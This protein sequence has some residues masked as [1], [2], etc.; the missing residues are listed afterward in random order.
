MGSGLQVLNDRTAQTNNSPVKMHSQMDLSAGPS[1]SKFCIYEVPVPTPYMPYCPNRSQT[2]Q[3]TVYKIQSETKSERIETDFFTPSQPEKHET[4]VVKSNRSKL[5]TNNI[6]GL[7]SKH[8][9][10]PKESHTKVDRDYKQQ[11]TQ[12]RGKHGNAPA[13]YGFLERRSPY[14]RQF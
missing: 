5:P 8:V 7:T 6:S 12:S 9:A 14:Q 4:L 11:Q 13:T 1:D 10:L 2:S 3:M